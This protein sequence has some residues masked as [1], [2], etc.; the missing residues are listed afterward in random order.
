MSIW[1]QFIWSLSNLQPPACALTLVIHVRH[2]SGGE[3]RLNFTLNAKPN[4][5][6]VY[7]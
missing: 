4:D 7:P 5:A 2:Q 3:L 6:A 1:H